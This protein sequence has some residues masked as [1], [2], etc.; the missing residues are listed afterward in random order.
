MSGGIDYDTTNFHALQDELKALNEAALAD[1]LV[2]PRDGRIAMPKRAAT[3][4]ARRPAPRKK[5]SSQAPAQSAA[6][7]KSRKP[8]KPAPDRS[9]AAAAR[10][11]AM[12]VRGADDKSPA[13]PGTR[14][15][16]A[17]VGRLLAHLRRRRSRRIGPWLRFLQRAERYLSRPVSSGVR[18]IEGIGLERLQ[19]FARQLDE[20]VDGGWPQFQAARATRRQRLTRTDTFS[21][22][23]DK[24]A[25]APARRKGNGR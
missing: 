8:R 22:Q 1:G 9:N 3:Q 19:V 15:T 25:P 23:Q 17:G 7:D 5:P 24:I 12:L 4:R 21:P 18:T 2:A 6:P 20:I 10:L 14:F 13:V 16:E 11:L